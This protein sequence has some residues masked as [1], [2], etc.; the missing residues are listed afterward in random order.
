MGYPTYPTLTRKT[1]YTPPPKETVRIVCPGGAVTPSFCFSDEEA[2]VIYK[3]SQDN[4][5]LAFANC[6]V[7]AGDLTV[8]RRPTARAR[9]HETV[10][11]P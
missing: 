3:E 8:S 7:D 4:A 6:L 5:Q 1:R 9:D 11:R 10:K 2:L